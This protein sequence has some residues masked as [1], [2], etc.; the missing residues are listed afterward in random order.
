MAELLTTDT[1]LQTVANAI[2]TKTGGSVGLTYPDGFASA[3]ESIGADCTATAADIAVGK[4]A[5]VG[6]AKITGSMAEKAAATYYTST[7][8]QTIAAGQYLKGA[9]T[10]G[11]VTTVNLAAGNIKAGVT[12]KVGDAEDDDRIAGITGNFTSDANA[13]AGHIL[14]G[15]TAYVN[16][17]KV[18]GNIA[19]LGATTYNLSAS[20]QT[21][22][23]GKYLSGAQTIRGVATQNLTAANVRKGVTVYVGDTGSVSRI[24]SVAGTCVPCVMSMPQSSD[25]FMPFM[26]KVADG[27]CPSFYWV[28]D[29]FRFA[30]WDTIP[31]GFRVPCDVKMTYYAEDTSTSTSTITFYTSSWY[32]L[33]SYNGSVAY[34]NSGSSTIHVYKVVKW[35]V[36]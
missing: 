35:E 23:S 24:A 10:I 11:K 14:S 18:T 7:S 26:F 27:P 12:V 4:T 32:T 17:S 21:I 36:V 6:D 16:G 8:D 2:R 3:I 22:A 25:C 15:K 29:G 31:H 5:Y 19:S 30:G 13:A 9:Q 28:G 1:E 34:I 33:G 20:N